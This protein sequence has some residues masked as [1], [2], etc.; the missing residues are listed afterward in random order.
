MMRVDLLITVAL[1]AALVVAGAAAVAAL[2]W[3]EEEL[4]G[5]EG[6]AGRVAVRAVRAVTRSA[7]RGSSAAPRGEPLPGGAAP[8]GG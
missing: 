4:R 7:R 3:R 5:V 8:A 2:P 1:S 6:A